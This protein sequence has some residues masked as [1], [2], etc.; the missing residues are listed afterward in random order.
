MQWNIMFLLIVLRWWCDDESFDGQSV[1]AVWIASWVSRDVTH[2]RRRTTVS[3][4]M[5]GCVYYVLCAICLYATV[6]CAYMWHYTRM[7]KTVIRKSHH[8]KSLLCWSSIIEH[9]GNVFWILFVRCFHYNQ[10]IVNQFPHERQ[11][12]L[13]LLLCVCNALILIEWKIYCISRWN[14]MPI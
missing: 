2:T 12:L 14:C 6:R 8:I 4:V 5:C 13:L 3:C 11:F 7:C 10:Q 1:D 9:V